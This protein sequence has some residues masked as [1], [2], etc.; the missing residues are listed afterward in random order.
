[1]TVGAC[2]RA[3]RTRRGSIDEMCEISAVGLA[4]R[5]NIC[6]EFDKGGRPGDGAEVERVVW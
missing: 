3:I 6:S 2:V 1:M 4:K 5:K